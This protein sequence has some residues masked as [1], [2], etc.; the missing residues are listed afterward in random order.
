ME[1]MFNM[2]E[3]TSLTRVLVYALCK[4]TF[5][6]R[7]GGGEGVEDTTIWKKDNQGRGKSQCKGPEAMGTDVSLGC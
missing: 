7:F 4:V 6:Q 3:V 2:G 5:E 1:K